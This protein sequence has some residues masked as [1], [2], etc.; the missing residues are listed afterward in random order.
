MCLALFCACEDSEE[1]PDENFTIVGTWRYHVPALTGM[2]PREGYVYNADG[3]ITFTADMRFCFTLDSDCGEVKGYGT[4]E[5]NEDS[6]I[7]LVY[8]GYTPIAERTVELGI[9]DLVPFVYE[10]NAIGWGWGESMGGDIVRDDYLKVHTIPVPEYFRIDT[11]P[12]EEV[13]QPYRPNGGAAC[14][15]LAHDGESLFDTPYE[16]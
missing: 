12:Y 8:D 13:V 5:Y 16:L 2:A 1:Y 4:Y 10:H 7:Y 15:Y 14:Y 3:R 11:A 9:Y 6:G